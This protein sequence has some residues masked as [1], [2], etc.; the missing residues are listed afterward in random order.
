MIHSM[1]FIND[2]AIVGL[3]RED[4]AAYIEETAFAPCASVPDVTD[5]TTEEAEA[6][7]SRLV[8]GVK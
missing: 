8:Y 2:R 5:M 6:E 4:I 7:M 1:T 3:S